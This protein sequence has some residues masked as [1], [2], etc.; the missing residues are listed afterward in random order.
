MP[1]CDVKK[2]G[3]FTPKL[4][5]CDRYVGPHRNTDIVVDLSPAVASLPAG[6][7]LGFIVSDLDPQEVLRFAQTL[8]DPLS[9]HLT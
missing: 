8:A 5:T 7:Y 3:W 4:E 1:C 9:Q 2:C 6:H